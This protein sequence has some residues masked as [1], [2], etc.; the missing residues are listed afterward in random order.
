MNRVAIWNGGIVPVE[1]RGENGAETRGNTEFNPYFDLGLLSEEVKEFYTAVANNDLVEMFDAYADMRFVWEGIEFKY[2]MIAYSYIADLEL[3]EFNEK[4]FKNIRNYY[5]EHSNTAYNCL[6]RQLG[7]KFNDKL[8]DN[9]IDAVFSYVCDANE[10]KGTAKDEKGKT[11]K[12]TK[13]VN[14]ADRIRQLLVSK[15]LL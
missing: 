5:W 14:P 8:L 6:R 4:Q 10:Q 3:F 7:H 13:W 11:I 12:G 2:G 1:L 9:L 15:G